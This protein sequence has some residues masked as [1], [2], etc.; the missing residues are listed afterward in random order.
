M[1]GFQV[2]PWA[3]PVPPPPS[4]AHPPGAVPP[5]LLTI[6]AGKLF[7]LHPTMLVSEEWTDNFNQ[8]PTNKQQNFRTILGPGMHLLINGPTT[9]GVI[10]GNAGLTYDTAPSS[11]FNVF[12]TGIVAVHQ[13]LSPRLSL[14]L[15]DAY[16][17]NDDPTQ[18]DVFGLNTQRQTFTSNSFS[19]AASYLIDEVT[20]QAYYRNSLFWTGGT[21][22]TNTVSN[23]L[24]LTADT[25]I[26]LYNAA[27]VGYEYSW[28]NTSGT[29]SGSNSGQSTGNLFTASLSRQTGEHSTLGVS[30]S[31]QEQSPPRSGDQHLW[32]V[33]LFGTY[34]LPSGLSLSGSIGYGQLSS[35][36]QS[37]TSAITTNSNLSYSF[38]R[39]IVAVGMFSDF[40][41]TALEG[42]N[43]GIVQ[44]QGYTGSILYTFT[45]FI[46]GSLQATYSQNSFTGSGNNSS[47]PNT[48]N[49]TGHARVAWHLLPWLIMNAQY[50]YILRSGANGSVTSPGNS[51]TNI[52]M[53]SLQ[54]T[55]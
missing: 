24:G 28:S 29:S 22:G 33:S 5:G 15:T 25:K 23:I 48:N 36:N 54:A 39:G 45:P 19:A 17:R 41:Q 46:T 55:F 10:S 14:A 4:Q 47:S 31:Y 32:N 50:S 16:I 21:N 8:T 9:R 6:G 1:E 52:V 20:T 44:T 37:P 7:E 53:I 30:G 35:N 26:G 2:P 49:I 12:P 38:G 3:P 51:S 34:G 42:Q 18:A 27:H 40:R 11:G 43:F 13:I